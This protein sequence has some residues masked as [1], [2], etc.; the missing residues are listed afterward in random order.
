MISDIYLI[1][2]P[3]IDNYGNDLSSFPISIPLDMPDE[4]ITDCINML[5]ARYILDLV[6]N[7]KIIDI[8]WNINDLAK[9]SKVY[10]SS[11]FSSLIGLMK[12]VARERSHGS[13]SLKHIFMSD[14]AYK[15]LLREIGLDEAPKTM[16]FLGAYVKVEPSLN[17]SRII[18]ICE[19]KFKYIDLNTLIVIGEKVNASPS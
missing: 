11:H 7:G 13:V 8:I 17:H 12:N 19:P 10:R 5:K 9:D 6:H 15:E 14:L 16:D 2:R 3:I 18:G 1:T 4:S